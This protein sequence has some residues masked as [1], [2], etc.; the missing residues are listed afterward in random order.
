MR[1]NAGFGSWCLRVFPWALAL[2]VV[3][4]MG[5]LAY[6]T[7]PAQSRYLSSTSDVEGEYSVPGIEGRIAHQRAGNAV[8]QRMI[9]AEVRAQRSEK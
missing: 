7:S 2:L 5:I 4:C 3:V 9:V 1:G 6:V 8:L